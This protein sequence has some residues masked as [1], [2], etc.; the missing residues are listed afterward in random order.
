MLDLADRPHKVGKDAGTVLQ[1]DSLAVAGKMSDSN[2]ARGVPSVRDEEPL[3]EAA[4]RL[5]LLWQQ[6]PRLL[7]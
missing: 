6:S 2:V 7:R 5:L 4:D 1:G 3:S